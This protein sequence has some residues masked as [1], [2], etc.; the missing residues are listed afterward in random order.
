MSVTLDLQTR[1]RMPHPRAVLTLIK[2]ITWFP[3]IWAYLCGVVSSGVPVMSAPW[4]VLAGV[5]LAGPVVCGMSQA[6]NDWCDRHVDAINEPERP[7]PSGQIPGRWGL[8]IALAMSG[9]A[10]GL[11]ALL[12]PWGFGATVFGVLAAWAYSAEPVRLKRSGVWGPGLVGLCYEGL[13]WFTGAAVL[14]AGA[15]AWPIVVIALLYALGA[16]GIMTLNDFKAL[17]GDR[18]TGVNS[19]PVT[20]GPERAAR[21]ACWVMA[22]PQVVVIG[23][24][25]LWNM[26]LFAAII[27]VLLLAQV[28]AMRV[29]LTDPKGRA[30]WYNG[31]GVMLYVS[32]MM[33]AAVALR[34]MG[35]G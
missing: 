1:R 33:V 2:P 11:G 22:V 19:L 30:P 23:L 34:M 28:W 21:V 7:I 31:T 18:Q 14:S 17:E 10:L 5:L 35:A 6:A 32:G 3:P 26:P 29:L 27:A 25:A 9:L 16:H 15:P 8:W 20:L 12:G 4:L 13:P 24:M